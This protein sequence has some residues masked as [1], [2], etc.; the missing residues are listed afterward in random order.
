MKREPVLIWSSVLVVLQVIV[1]GTAL[2]D[3]L[4]KNVAALLAV[5]VAALQA[6][7]QFYVRGQVAPV[8]P[9]T[10]PVK[11]EGG[12]IDTGTA[13]LIAVLVLVVVVVLMAALP[14]W[15]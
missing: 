15:R 6:G 10:R 12:A 3:T 4:G 2:T 14:G 11:P 7:T 5:I 13:V 1:A 9:V 8:E